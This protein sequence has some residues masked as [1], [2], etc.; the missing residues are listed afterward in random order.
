MSP[1][2]INSFL[3][4]LKLEGCRLEIL[5]SLTAPEW[6]ATE[7]R[8]KIGEGREVE[9]KKFGPDHITWTMLKAVLETSTLDSA[10][11][12]NLTFLHLQE[13]GFSM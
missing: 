13:V 5:Q 6:K 8:T 9:G 12:L 10:V 1:V 3:L 2:Q 11:A 7:D 4:N